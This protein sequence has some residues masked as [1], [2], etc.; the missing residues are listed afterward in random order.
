M[1]ASDLREKLAA[2]EHERWADWQ[3]Y[4][5]SKCSTP[6]ARGIGHLLPPGSLIIPG[7]YVEKL[8]RQIATP[9]GE[10]TAFEQDSDMDQVDRYWGVIVE[11]FAEWVLMNAD[12]Y[13]DSADGTYGEVVARAFREEWA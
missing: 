8:E 3:K 9:Y 5:H 4:L 11:A 10:L 6:A 2:I 12:E 13:E 1:N 7:G